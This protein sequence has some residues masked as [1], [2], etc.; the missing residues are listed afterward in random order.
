M[1]LVMAFSALS[2]NISA[3][4]GRSTSI[5][6]S[7]GSASGAAANGEGHALEFELQPAGNVFQFEIV[8]L[9][10]ADGFLQGGT[11]LSNVR[12]L[13]SAW[14]TRTVILGISKSVF[15]GRG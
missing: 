13:G 1:F 5:S 15:F 14:G 10:I 6:T 4:K 3:A 7:V 2:L 12:R 8:P 9:K 11:N